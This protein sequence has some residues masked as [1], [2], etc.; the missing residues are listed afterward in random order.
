MRA[1][2]FRLESVAR[3]RQHQERAA[4]NRFALATRDVR[5]AQA[6]CADLRQATGQLAFPA[7]RS[8]MAALL[9]VQDQSDRMAV[10]VRQQ[11]AVAKRAEAQA[12]EARTSWVEAEQRCRALERL[13]TRQRE[14]WELDAARTVA[15]ELDDMATIRFRTGRGAP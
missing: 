3:V 7:G 2:R 10:L 4:A 14:R 8:D 6:R 15:A 5:V 1:F 12:F 11:D 9:W 13:Q